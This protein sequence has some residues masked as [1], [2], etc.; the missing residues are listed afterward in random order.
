MSLHS[1][2]HG[3]VR[4]IGAL[5]RARMNLWHVRGAKHVFVAFDPIFARKR[6]RG[7]LRACLIVPL[8]PELCASLGTGSSLSGDKALSL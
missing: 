1:W 3:R 7:L 6:G 4:R 2:C 8:Y 5:D